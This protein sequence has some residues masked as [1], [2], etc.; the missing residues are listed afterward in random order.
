MSNKLFLITL[1]FLSGSVFAQD[2]P[3]ILWLVTEDMSPYLSCYGNK[4]IKTPNLDK[5]AEGGIR[6]TKAHSNSVQCSP[7]RSTLIT[8]IYAVSLGTDMHRAQRPVNDAYY[9]PIYL[10]NAGYYTTN[11]NK[12]DYNNEKTPA[13]V[14]N[15]SNGKAN[16]FDRPDK[17]QPFFAVYNQGI[18]HM[19][20]VIS[21]LDERK[22]SREVRMEDVQVP[23]YIPDLPEVRN[24]ISWNMGAVVMMDNWVGKMI[25]ELK[26]KGEYENTIIFFFSDHGGTVPRGKAYVYESGTHIPFI[27]SFPPKWKH[28]AATSVPSVSDRL[29]SFRDFG[30]T[31]LSL[32]GAKIPA[33]ME[34]KPFFT[35]AAKRK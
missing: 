17:K 24:D 2:R 22:G 25:E 9:F 5:L 30:P 11:N 10:I 35:E 29:V 32:A 19:T 3:N 34:G 27:V 23:P 15:V 14:W 1:L 28:L 4:L 6:F 31:V 12:Q 8:G 7:S 33:F 21:P 26:A 13:T 16:Y 18:T 20:R